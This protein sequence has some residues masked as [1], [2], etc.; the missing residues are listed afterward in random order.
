VLTLDTPEPPA[1]DAELHYDGKT[2]GRVT[3][4]ARRDDGGL[5]ALAYVR[6]DVPEDAE[7]A[8]DPVGSARGYTV[9]SARP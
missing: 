4:V 9:S 7:L 8:L 2:V 3:S 5:V 1:Y 6:T